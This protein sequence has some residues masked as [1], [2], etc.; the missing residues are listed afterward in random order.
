MKLFKTAL[1]ALVLL[2]NLII[3]QP[4]WADR[5]DLTTTPDYIEVNQ[6]INNVLQL[7][8]TPEQSQY[9]PEQIEQ[10]LGELKLQKYILETAS[11]WAQC[12]N[13]TG[14]TLAIYAHKPKKVA[15]GNTLYFLGNGQITENEWDCDGVYLPIGTKVAGIAADGQALTEPLAIKIVDGTQLIA[16]T[17]PQTGTIEFNV[18][19]AR[20]FK[21]GEPN[22][23]I[24]NLSQADIDAAIPNAPI[25]D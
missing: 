8:N 5:P 3:A 21:A 10:E 25:E 14:K 9:T 22:W 16:K 13:E 11:S 7:K 17:N 1:V 24:P 20:V 12:R 18:N 6:V 23:S 2:V 15:Q 4:S 19:P